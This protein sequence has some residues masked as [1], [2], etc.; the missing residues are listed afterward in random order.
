MRKKVLGIGEVVVDKV[1]MLASFPNEGEKVSAQAVQ[2]TLGGPVPAALV[3]LARL[4]VECALVTS[5]AR[6]E[7]G[8][9]IRTILSK[10]DIVL[11]AQDI[12]TTPV[13]TVLINE[14]TG[15]RTII[16][17]ASSKNNLKA[18][19]EELVQSADIILSDR[20]EPTAMSNAIHN[21]RSTTLTLMDP[22]VDCSSQTIKLLK[23]IDF[24]IIPIETLHLLYPAQSLQEGS[25]KLSLLLGKPVVITMGQYGCAVWDDELLTIHPSHPV[26]VVDTLGA[27][28]VFRGGFA[29]GLLQGWDIHNC[30]KF[31]NSVAALQCTKRGNCSAIPTKLEIIT[32]QKTSTHLLNP[33]V[34]I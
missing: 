30:A 27:G 19:S 11:L 13:H 28:D 31:A 33:I 14:Q 3:L 6:D 24:P 8:E 5:I 21:K 9:T 23:E 1:H 16:K 2:N 4:G 32:M 25:K 7:A 26:K 18:V 17:D 12:L 20:H 34:L 22:S 10:E 29:Y 15:S